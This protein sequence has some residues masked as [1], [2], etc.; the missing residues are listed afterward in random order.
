[1]LLDSCCYAVYSVQGTLVTTATW[2][3]CCGVSQP[4][5]KKGFPGLKESTLAKVMLQLRTL[6]NVMLQQDTLVKVM[7][8]LDTLVNIIKRVK[9]T[10]NRTK[11]GSFPA[12]I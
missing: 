10:T 1:M 2:P 9:K 8:Q 7:L 11:I 12:K 4:L 6:V 5:N 3:L